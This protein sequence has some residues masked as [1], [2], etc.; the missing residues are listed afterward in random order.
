MFKNSNSFASMMGSHWRGS[1]DK[2]SKM[3]HAGLWVRMLHPQSFTTYHKLPEPLNLAL[4]IIKF[5][6]VQ[7][8]KALNYGLQGE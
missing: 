4:D 7:L 3:L 6:L 8:V 2:G 1:P 5:T